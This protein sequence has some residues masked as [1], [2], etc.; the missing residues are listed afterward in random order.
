MSGKVTNLEQ[1]RKAALVYQSQAEETGKT[2]G[3]AIQEMNARLEK[4]LTTD[5]VLS[6]AEIM[7]IMEEN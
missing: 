5:D 7:K 3:S 1:M 4:V 2:T 6:V